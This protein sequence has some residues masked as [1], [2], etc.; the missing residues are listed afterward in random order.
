VEAN[1]KRS[2]CK[3][4]LEALVA[5]YPPLVNDEQTRAIVRQYNRD[6]GVG[7]PIWTWALLQTRNG[8]SDTYAYFFDLHAADKPH[9]APHATEYPYIFGNFPN[10]HAQRDL[11]ASAMVRRYLLNFAASGNPNGPGLPQ[12]EKFDE[13]TQRVMVLD[14]AASSREWPNLAALRAL[15]PYL[16]CLAGIPL[17]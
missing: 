2:P 3:H 7:W 12:W 1:L 11:A 6:E 17:R 4:T 13:T 14:D 10:A 8:R 5:A 16:Q 9:G 15:T